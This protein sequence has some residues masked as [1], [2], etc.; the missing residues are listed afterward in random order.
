MCSHYRLFGQTGWLG[1]LLSHTHTHAYSSLRRR[2][3]PVKVWAKASALLHLP[4]RS[5]RLSVRRA[6]N[7]PCNLFPL[8]HSCNLQRVKTPKDIEKLY[9]I[10]TFQGSSKQCSAYI[11]AI[12]TILYYIWHLVTFAKIIIVLVLFYSISHFAA[13]KMSKCSFK[14]TFTC[15]TSVVFFFFPRLN[16]SFS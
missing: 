1:R 4:H 6:P 7:C 9:R 8:K 12:W 3:K 5:V 11:M 2:L 10:P 13:Q 15:Q 14:R 16:C